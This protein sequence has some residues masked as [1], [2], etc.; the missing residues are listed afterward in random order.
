ML[1]AH[2]SVAICGC[3]PQKVQFWHCRDAPFCI[4]I[5][6]RA[7]WTIS[8]DRTLPTFLNGAMSVM[9]SQAAV[10]ATATSALDPLVRFHGSRGGYVSSL[11]CAL[12]RIKRSVLEMMDHIQTKTSSLGA[13]SEGVHVPA[14]ITSSAITP[15]TGQGPQKRALIRAPCCTQGSMLRAHSSVA[16]CGVAVCG[17]FSQK[18]KFGSA[19]QY[20]LALFGLSP[21][22]TLPSFLNCAMSVMSSPVARHTT[23]NS[24]CAPLVR[25]QCRK[26]F[27]FAH[28]C[29]CSLYLP[30]KTLLIFPKAK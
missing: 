23:V 29:A 17:C 7:F 28:G 10:H 8:L 27:W 13:T 12:H 11:S 2:S 9:S 24:A 18:V 20:L 25:F 19:Y 26:G 30:K 6:A 5:F 4:S 21:Y 1:R 3:F 15:S 22:M 14:L 16:V